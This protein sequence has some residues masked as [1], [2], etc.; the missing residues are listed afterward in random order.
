MGE[1]FSI[2][3]L[4]L[5]G[6]LTS[7]GSLVLLLLLLRK[8]LEGGSILGCQQM[9]MASVVKHKIRQK[10]KELADLREEGVGE[11]RRGSQLLHDEERVEQKE[12]SSTQV[13]GS[14]D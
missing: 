14:S 4:F 2:Y 3:F 10:T 6:L 9:D 5:Q 13:A 1:E 7:F 12:S 8:W 11:G